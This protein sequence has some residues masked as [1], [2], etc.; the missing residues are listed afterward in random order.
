MEAGSG[1]IFVKF[2]SYEGSKWSHGGPTMFTMEAW[3]ENGAEEGPYAS[4]RRFAEDPDP[5][6]TENRIRIFINVK[7]RIRIRIKLKDRIRICIKMYV[8]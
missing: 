1:S 5:H 6:Q 4:G 7:C 3:R 8:L 2:R